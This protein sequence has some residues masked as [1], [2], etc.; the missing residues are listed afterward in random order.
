[1]SSARQQGFIEAPVEVIWR[2]LTDVER[3]PRWWP[4][5]LEVECDG[6]E[7]GCTYRQ[8]TQTPIGKDEMELL[9]DRLDEYK[10]L[11]IQCINSGTF[12]RM[13]LAPAQDGTFIEGEMGM[14]P[15]RFSA[16][17]IDTLGGKRFFN[18][19][20]RETFDALAR[21]AQADAR[22]S[23]GQSAIT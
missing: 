6:L 16:R 18:A 8:V 20:L 11:S 13:Q 22:P 7:A 23:P 9:V 4:R 21:E 14:E 5:V 19:W 15:K 2:L 12:V 1:M 3:H 10:N 17:V